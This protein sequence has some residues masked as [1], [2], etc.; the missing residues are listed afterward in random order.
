MIMDKTNKKKHIINH[1]QFIEM[2]NINKIFLIIFNEN[3]IFIEKTT[4][5]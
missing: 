2:K 3:L 1:I 5:L 4:S